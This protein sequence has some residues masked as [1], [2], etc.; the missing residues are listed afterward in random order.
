MHETSNARFLFRCLWSSAL[1]WRSTAQ[2]T[3]APG[4]CFAQ[5]LLTR[6]GKQQNVARSMAI[7]LCFHFRGKSRIV[8]QI[9]KIMCQA[10]LCWAPKYCSLLKSVIPES[11]VHRMREK[12]DLKSRIRCMMSFHTREQRMTLCVQL[13]LSFECLNVQLLYFYLLSGWKRG[14][15]FGVEYQVILCSARPLEAA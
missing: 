9:P 10:D 8:Y 7:C 6:P 15:K 2:R 13:Q 4:G 5:T 11:H 14:R 3:F 12:M 1:M